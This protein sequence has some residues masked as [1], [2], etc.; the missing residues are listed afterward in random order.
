MTHY[1]VLLLQHFMPDW[2]EYEDALSG[3]K[4]YFNNITKE[5]TWKPPRKAKTSLPEGKHYISLEDL[6]F[7]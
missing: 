6:T 2:D 4:F 5:K 7:I 1:T 3:R